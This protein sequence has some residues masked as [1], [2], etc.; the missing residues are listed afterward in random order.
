MMTINLI[1]IT[2]LA[3]DK[4]DITIKINKD[5]VAHDIILGRNRK[6]HQNIHTSNLVV[7][8][9]SSSL[10]VVCNMFL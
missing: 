9:V 1:M 6:A 7:F 10:V 4:H 5:N 8:L 2:G 3:H